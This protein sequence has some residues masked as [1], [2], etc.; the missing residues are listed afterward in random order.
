MYDVTNNATQFVHQFGTLFANE[1]GTNLTG[2]DGTDGKVS[3]SSNAGQIH[4]ENRSG[5]TTTIRLLV[6]F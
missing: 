1:G 3:I 4:V 6:I 5:S 2:I